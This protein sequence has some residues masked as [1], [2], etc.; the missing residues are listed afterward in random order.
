MLLPFVFPLFELRGLRLR[1]FRVM[2]D[3]TDEFAV[4]Q[5]LG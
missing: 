5:N 3:V 1:Y 2:I 4:V